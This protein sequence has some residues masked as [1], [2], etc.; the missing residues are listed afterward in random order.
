VDLVAF[1]ADVGS[2][3][4]TNPYGIG[5]SKRITTDDLNILTRRSKEFRIANVEEVIGA[6][7]LHPG[8]FGFVSLP[9]AV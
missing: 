2:R 7:L 1:L 4:L 6:S 5:E 3:T 8:Y 9:L